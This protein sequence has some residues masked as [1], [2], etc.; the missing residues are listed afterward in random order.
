[1][2]RSKRS[3]GNKASNIKTQNNPPTLSSDQQTK[4]SVASNNMELQQH[5]KD[6]L[7]LI[8]QIQDQKIQNL[9]NCINNLEQLAHE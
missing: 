3:N 4:V 9:T 6:E 2:A 8:I 1:M 5:S 7:M